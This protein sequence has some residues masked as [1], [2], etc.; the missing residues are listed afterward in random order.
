M[1]DY[2]EHLTQMSKI[3]KQLRTALL[4][5]KIDMANELAMMLLTESRLLL[6]C[7]AELKRDMDSRK[8]LG[9]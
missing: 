2:G 7:V 1:S 8:A 5:Q 3:N 4:N 6:H 9:I